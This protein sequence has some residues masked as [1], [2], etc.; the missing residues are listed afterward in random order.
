MRLARPAAYMISALLAV[1]GPVAQA[2][3]LPD[4]RTLAKAL[5]KTGKRATE[6]SILRADLVPAAYRAALE[7]AVEIQHYFEAMAASPDE[8]MLAGS[9]FLAANHHSAAAAHAAA[10]AGCNS[11]KK[12]ASQS[13]VVIAEFLPKGYKG[14]GAFSLSHDATE[15]F[16]KE[17]RR[18][19]APKAFA[20]S[21]AA[22]S[23]GA[24]T[25][26]GSQAA[27]SEAALADCAA[28]AA[29]LGVKDCRLVSAE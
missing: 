29:K 12:S 11:K 9:A 1:C 20:I 16:A 3:D 5:Y 23:W 27:A 21:P 8:G 18:A 14:A 4:A 24:A 13:C 17:Y 15:Y 28:K 2:Q 19:K 26:A 22:G 6:V 7:N 10:I 25:G